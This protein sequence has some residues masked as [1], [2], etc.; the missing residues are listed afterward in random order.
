LFG[1]LMRRALDLIR[2]CPCTS[3]TGCPG[4]VQH[5]D[6][7]EYNAVLNKQ[8]AILILESTLAAEAERAAAALQR[9]QVDEP[10]GSGC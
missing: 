1:L 3:D 4:C 8:S 10:Q 6:C 9:L 5:T 7:G 2:S